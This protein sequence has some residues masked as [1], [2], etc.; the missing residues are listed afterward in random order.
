MLP[1]F[2]MQQAKIGLSFL[3]CFLYFICFATWKISFLDKYSLYFPY[4]IIFGY[5]I[6]VNIYISLLGMP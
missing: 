3:Q 6:P 4:V 5:S 2:Y 1:A